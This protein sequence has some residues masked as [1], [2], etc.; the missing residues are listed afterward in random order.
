MNQSLENFYNSF[1]ETLLSTQKVYTL[2][3]SENVALCP[4]NEY[5]T[6]NGK[7]A[8]VL[9]FWSEKEKAKKC[10]AQEWEMYDCIEIPLGEFLEAWCL[11]M[12]EDGV[13]V[14]IDF[15]ENLVGYE[16]PPF[17]VAKTLIQKLI[18]KQK[19]VQ[20]THFTSLSELNQYLNQIEMEF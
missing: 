3:N 19:S 13:I 10:Q 11:G 20:L 17:E 12:I 14:G 9:A 6:T 18:Q 16:I 7:E 4:S 2:G 1:I 8:V 15:T 5:N